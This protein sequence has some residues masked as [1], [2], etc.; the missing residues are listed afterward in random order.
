MCCR[1]FLRFPDISSIPQSRH[2]QNNSRHPQSNSRHQQQQVHTLENQ[3]Q[4]AK[5]Q[6]H[7]S[8]IQV[9]TSQIQVQTS[10]IQILECIYPYIAIYSLLLSAEAGCYIYVYIYIYIYIY[11]QE[12]RGRLRAAGK[13]Y[14]HLAADMVQKVGF[15][16]AGIFLP[17]CGYFFTDA[18]KN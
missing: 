10:K 9:Q 13:I 2:P 7:T 3:I 5:I 1:A 6:I 4:T 18:V 15:T 16:D 8:K 11:T 12:D 17:T 14:F